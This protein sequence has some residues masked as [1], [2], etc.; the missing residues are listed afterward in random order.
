ME[1]ED[2]MLKNLKVILVILAF[3][4]LLPIVA[5]QLPFPNN[6]KYEVAKVPEKVEDKTV[7]LASA[8]TQAT[9]TDVSPS[10][11]PF[12]VL[13]VFTHS[14]ETYKPFVQSQNGKIA[15]YDSQTN[16]FSMQTRMKDYF[17]LNGLT[18]K[19]L[20]VDVMEVMSQKGHAFHKAYSTA[21]PF[22]IEELKQNNYDLILDI[23]RDSLTADRTTVTHNNVTYA[24]VAFVIGAENSNFRTNLQ[25]ANT[26]NSAL[27][28]IVPNLS[29]GVIQKKGKGVD[30]VY[31]QDLAGEM[32]L[33]E[34][35]GIDN[36]EDE[37]YRTVAV[38]AQAISKALVGNN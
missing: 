24:K 30:G 34:I 22:I 12:N 29:R 17:Q 8:T 15:V 5:G 32:V 38:L 18:A 10:L 2:A 33:V 13:F 7:V 1:G 20:D 36:T 9:A 26:L 23:H 3:F 35:G 27:N 6:E 19:T 21:R 4:F 31:N 11:D 28:Q 25:Y 37:V 14:H 16:L